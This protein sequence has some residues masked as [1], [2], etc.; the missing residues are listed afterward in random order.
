MIVILVLLI[1]FNV[2]IMGQVV[3]NNASNFQPV[4]NNL[5]LKPRVIATN[6]CEPPNPYPCAFEANTVCVPDV[7]SQYHCECA[8]GYVRDNKGVCNSL[9]NNVVC[10]DPNAICDENV[11]DGR[12][13]CLNKRGRTF[14]KGGVIICD[15]NNLN[16]NCYLYTETISFSYLHFLPKSI[17]PIK[18]IINTGNN[19]GW[20]V[21]LPLANDNNIFIQEN[22]L[23][24]DSE[25]IEL[26]D[27]DYE[28]ILN[29]S[30]FYR[31][32][33]IIQ[34][35]SEQTF[36][37][38]YGDVPH[39]ILN[40]M[41]EQNYDFN[42]KEF[43]IKGE[44]HTGSYF[45]TSFMVNSIYFYDSK[46]YKYPEYQRITSESILP[47]S[48]NG[49]VITDDNTDLSDGLIVCKDDDCMSLR[50]HDYFYDID[51]YSENWPFDLSS[52]S[53]KS[54]F[55]DA[56]TI[57]LHHGWEALLCK[58]VNSS[59]KDCKKLPNAITYNNW[60]EITSIGGGAFI[61]KFIIL[62]PNNKEKLDRVAGM[63]YTVL[64]SDPN[65][66][67]NGIVY[68]KM[69]ERYP[70]PIKQIRSI[71]SVG[72][73]TYLNLNTIEKFNFNGKLSD[74]Y[75]VIND[76][77]YLH[78]TDS[79]P[80]E[81]DSIPG[82]Y[83]SIILEKEYNTIKNEGVELILN[84]DGKLCA[85][86]LQGR[87][88]ENSIISNVSDCGVEKTLG[89]LL[90]SEITYFEVLEGWEVHICDKNENCGFIDTNTNGE[91]FKNMLFDKYIDDKGN[92][93]GKMLIQPKNHQK[94]NQFY[95]HKEYQEQNGI[96]AL[97]GYVI[98]YKNNKY[99]D[100]YLDVSFN[101]Y[102]PS[103]ICGG[104]EIIIPKQG[105]YLNIGEDTI[106]KP[107]EVKGIRV[108][109]D[110]D[111]NIWGA[112]RI[113]DIFNQ[114]DTL[115]AGNYH[116][117]NKYL[118]TDYISSIDVSSIKRPTVTLIKALTPGAEF[119]NGMVK[120]KPEN[121]NSFALR[122]SDSPKCYREMHVVKEKDWKVNEAGEEYNQ[123]RDMDNGDLLV[124]DGHGSWHTNKGS[125]QEI[126][127]GHTPL[128]TD[129]HDS[130]DFLQYSES[131]GQSLADYETDWIITPA[132]NSLGK[133]NI[134]TECEYYDD[135]TGNQFFYNYGI[136]DCADDEVECLNTTT[137]DNEE[138]CNKCKLNGNI[139]TNL[140]ICNNL[141]MHC[142]DHSSNTKE[143]EVLNS[144][145]EHFINGLHGLGGMYKLSFW[146]CYNPF[147]DCGELAEDFWDYIKDEKSVA[148]SYLVALGSEG[149]LTPGRNAGYIAP[150]LCETVIDYN[151]LNHH[152][153]GIIPSYVYQDH[154]WGYGNTLPDP[155]REFIKKYGFCYTSYWSHCDYHLLD[156]DIDISLSSIDIDVDGNYYTCENGRHK[157]F[158]DLNPEGNWD[159][160]IGSSVNEQVFN[161]LAS[162]FN[163]DDSIN[164]SGRN[165][166]SYL[167]DNFGRDYIEISNDSSKYGF[168]IEQK[169]VDN[170]YQQAKIFY[171]TIFGALLDDYNLY[172]VTTSFVSRQHYDINGN[173][174]SKV[175]LSEIVFNFEIAY[176]GHLFLDNN[177]IKIGVN[178]LTGEITFV[179]SNII[180]I[181]KT[182]DFVTTAKVNDFFNSLPKKE[183]IIYRKS[184]IWN[185]NNELRPAV[186][187]IDYNSA[188]IKIIKVF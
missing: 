105:E 103:I 2:G 65:Y 74:R 72:N 109:G 104:K 56:D 124:I 49:F 188:D 68:W 62:Q 6:P 16:G 138:V 107:E 33:I 170:Y 7:G 187:S 116:I 131:Q 39:V 126:M 132:C 73:N 182:N 57:Y 61:P 51:H 164:V 21:Y 44:Y 41:N 79:T 163:S 26:T 89:E 5:S 183:N 36:L 43:F 137:K 178:T 18:G 17:K 10:G 167:S 172:A 158:S 120:F 66:S 141:K 168:H 151:P 96:N 70:M 93:I 86:F 98:L 92:I 145:S 55:N 150:G 94:M 60:I 4:G 176:N 106:F 166:V 157:D 71:Y 30:V 154:Y 50:Y 3:V 102:M 142:K 19:D 1:L 42:I 63:N 127:G 58:E 101:N 22:I 13:I 123:N 20:N 179:K 175:F 119:G 77:K 122:G 143:K 64:Y 114:C 155:N 181:D 100:C 78:T 135:V 159:V 35:L 59:L 169:I 180:T 111:I 84:I 24:S 112:P 8:E 27:A 174:D 52:K 148:F 133:N 136:K 165:G 12:A 48:L 75:L 80:W 90:K 97:D 128:K 53:T 69:N 25:I 87:L 160:L 117:E 153:G 28:V 91:D 32:T 14:D 129:S 95:G 173:K 184:Y 40:Y 99:K 152:N 147:D 125:S 115:E 83:N 54:V 46:L 85:S 134:C 113:C 139:Y 130:K 88:N 9:C 82:C 23:Y 45:F 140:R 31:N 15:D 110:I 177:N 34:P 38:V 171:D 76:D 146:P 67:G 161:H 144:Y 162:Y 156:I 118:L 186:Y 185:K 47:I 121:S 29:D 108:V 81:F 11:I 37:N 149:Y